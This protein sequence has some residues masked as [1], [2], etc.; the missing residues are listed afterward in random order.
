MSLDG[1]LGLKPKT[2]GT[3]ARSSGKTSKQTKAK[4]TTKQPRPVEPEDDDVRVLEPERPSTSGTSRTIKPKMT[5]SNLPKITADSEEGRRRDQILHETFGHKKFRTAAQGN[6]INY[7]LRKKT[8]VYISFPTGAG[9]S[10]CYQLPAL[11]H[12]GV[13]IVFSPLIAL[14]QDQILACKA[15]NIKCESLNSTLKEAERKAILS[16]LQRDT[17]TI[18][19]LYIT[20]EG[21]ATDNMRRIITSLHKRGILNYFVVDE[22]HCVSHWGHDFRPDY[23]KLG[24]LRDYAPGVP[25]VALTATASPAVEEDIAEQLHLNKVKK[26]KL[27]TFRE[28]LF[29]DVIIKD[30]ITSSPEKNM[31]DFIRRIISDKCSQKRAADGEKKAPKGGTVANGKKEKWNGSGIIY[32]KSR[33]DCEDMVAMLK[34]QEIPSYA[35]HA[36][37][38]AK[39]RN[40]VQ[41]KWMV[42]EIPVIA[43]TIAFGMGI[44]K[45][46]VR[47]VVHWTSPQ[48]LAAYY[49]ESGRAGRDGKRSYCRIYFSKEDRNC[50]SFLVGRSMDEVR[51]K[52]I[53]E[54]LKTEQIKAIRTGFEKMLNYVE[55]TKCR[56][57]ARRRSPR[58]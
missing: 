12:P 3:P 4:P 42:N 55:A 6:A 38:N 21:A 10:L 54:A 2:E 9:K 46:D 23:L 40:E 8:D 19:M 24:Q 43:A 47:F 34:T 29:Y 51:A 15:K 18:R 52:K 41:D 30:Q 37:L 25:W 11:F 56:H 49:Q 7:I 35:Y 45:P 57:F 31:A 14:I 22:A 13:T 28:N 16:D 5:S 53:S 58:L 36:G 39:T 20:P 27:S 1:W 32:C 44:D 17:P 50:L 33:K 26:F 48:N